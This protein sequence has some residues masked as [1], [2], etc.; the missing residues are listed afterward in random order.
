MPRAA[1]STAARARSTA[2][3][4]RSRDAPQALD[5]AGD[6]V[7]VDPLELDGPLLGLL[8]TVH[9]DDGALPRLDRLLDAE[10]G[11]VDLVLEEAGLD[12]GDRAAHRVDPLQVLGGARLELVRERLDEVGAAERVGH[13]R[14]ARLQREDLLRAERELRG[15]LGGQRERLVERS[16]CAA[17]GSPRAPPTAPRARCGRCCSA[18]AGP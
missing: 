14:D 9:P 5:L 6:L 12:R 13:V 11:L 4:S 3:P 17:T 1:A 15:L 2:V 7:L 8:E 16:S 18:A 10:G